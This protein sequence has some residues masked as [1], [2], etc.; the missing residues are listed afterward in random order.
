MASN[1]NKIIEFA[2]KIPVN[3]RALG[4]KGQEFTLISQADERECL[5]HNHGLVAVN[6]F[7][8]SFYLMPRRQGCVHLRGHFI[9]EVIQ[10][11][12]ISG[13]AI[14]QQIKDDFTL[15]FKP[16]TGSAPYRDEIIVDVEE[17]DVEFFE[18]DEID[19]GAVVE[20]FFCLTL[21]P[22]PRKPGAEFTSM[23][24]GNRDSQAETKPES[25]FNI[26]KKIE[27]NS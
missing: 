3:I 11:C 2:H 14:T 20:E 27:G 5:A 7:E 6:K 16:H 9:A 24:I 10:N 21:D 26:L 23:Q 17:E 22:Y 4:R 13:E 8:A 1:D 18:G 15:L 19:L 12:V 25:P